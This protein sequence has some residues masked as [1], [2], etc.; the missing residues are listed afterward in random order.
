MI[1]FDYIGIPRSSWWYWHLKK[2]RRHDICHENEASI[3]VYVMLI[4]LAT[5]IHCTRRPILTAIY[6]WDYFAMLRWLIFALPIFCALLQPPSRHYDKLSSISRKLEN[7]VSRLR[8]LTSDD[9]IALHNDIDDTLTP[10]GA[11]ATWALAHTTPTNIIS[12]TPSRL[13][14]RFY[15]PHIRRYFP[16]DS[17]SFPARARCA[18]MRLRFGL[19]SRSRA[20]KLMIFYYFGRREMIIKLAIV[21]AGRSFLSHKAP[22]RCRFIYY[23][24]NTSIAIS[25]THCDDFL[26]FF[27]G[28]CSLAA[29]AYCYD[30]ARDDSAFHFTI[31][32]G[33]RS[34][35]F[36]GDTNNTW[37]HEGG[38]PAPD[39]HWD[40]HQWAYQP[41]ARCAR[42]FMPF[43]QHTPLPILFWRR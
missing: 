19:L 32:G 2:Q 26:T 8:A 14:K 37:R 6:E 39:T 4:S 20:D 15:G 43:R 1:G 11:F 22:Q 24:I 5:I 42:C 23:V 36:G 33:P 31:F 18:M 41:R 10:T 28:L 29:K 17:I 13:K 7:M 3:P 35:D 21:N 40:C 16:R 9:K 25:S 34:L 12:I 30:D 38:H 27:N